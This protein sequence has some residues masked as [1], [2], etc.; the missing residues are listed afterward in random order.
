MLQENANQ[1]L[2]QYTLYLIKTEQHEL[3]PLYAC[4]MRQDVRRKTYT[5]YLHDLTQ[6][7]VEDCFRAYELAQECFDQWHRGDI[8][9][10][11][12]LDKIVEQVGV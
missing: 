3:V 7:S 2:E 12:E 6:Y 8:E 11:T 9:I 5:Q 1:L 4:L 10:G